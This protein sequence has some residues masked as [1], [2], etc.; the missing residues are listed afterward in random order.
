MWTLDSLLATR[1]HNY[2]IRTLKA[3]FRKPV[4]PG[5]EVTIEHASCP[6]ES[7][8]LDI[9][10][11]GEVK[12][13]VEVEL[14]QTDVVTSQKR[15][16]HLSA[17]PLCEPLILKQTDLS[18]RE[19]SLVLHLP[20]TEYQRL[21]PNLARSIEPL[22][23]SALLSISRLVG[24]KCPGLNSILHEINVSD[25]TQRTRS[26]LNYRV[27]GFDERTQR[28]SMNVGSPLLSGGL[29]TFVRPD[30]ARQANCSELDELVKN[31][32]FSDQNALVIGA[33][34]GR[35]EV[36]AK[37]LAMGGA[38]VT[39]TF[40]LGEQDAE[41][42]TEEINSAD[43]Q[44]RFLHLDVTTSDPVEPFAKRSGFDPT[45]LY[46]FC[47]PRIP[48]NQTGKFS[49]ENLKDLFQFYVSYFTKLTG[50]LVESRLSRAFYPST[51]FIE[52]TPPG[53]QEYSVAKSAGEAACAILEQTYPKL[54]IYRPR[55]PP[56]NTDQT[57]SILPARHHE[58]STL[59]LKHLR[60]FV[61][62]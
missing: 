8:Q 51:T 5:N 23:A 52:S 53:M 56:T 16:P 26:R 45:H 4:F 11:N 29:I 2:R 34:R 22:Q 3:L 46:Y 62:L 60:E 1:K 42:V 28:L 12:A 38:A 15:S 47:S 55:L 44:I 14:F 58:P 6:G 18:G 35:G 43:G 21:F 49:T 39:G 30:P 20:Q 57:A 25:K 13:Q 59:I 32:E 40:N 33:S 7:I 31:N 10:T 50:I 54:R 17:P 27:A 24:V 19:G 37:L 36:T 48:L 41:R 61:S 9:T